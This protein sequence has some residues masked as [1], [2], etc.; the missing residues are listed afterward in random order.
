VKFCH[1]CDSICC[2]TQFILPSITLLQIA[3]AWGASDPSGVAG[4]LG[5][6]NGRKLVSCNV[7]GQN[8]DADGASISDIVRCLAHARQQS[9]HWVVNLSLGGEWSRTD[10]AV[11]LLRQG[12]NTHVCEAGGI[13]VVAAHNFGINVDNPNLSKAT[14]PAAYAGSEVPCLIA[15]ASVDQGD[16]LSAFSNFG[17]AVKIAAPVRLLLQSEQRVRAAAEVQLKS[18]GDKCRRS[19][20]NTFMV[21]RKTA[22]RA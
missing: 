18:G 6:A 5:P 21:F 2:L 4:I 17:T 12:L 9:S 8:G 10:A 22:C 19:S 20:S 14:F 11:A 7:F 3:G 15:V 16:A 13:A 1:S